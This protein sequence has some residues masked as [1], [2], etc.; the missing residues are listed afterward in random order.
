M[1]GTNEPRKIVC[2]TVNVNEPGQP[3]LISRRIKK[4]L[5]KVCSHCGNEYDFC[6]DMI[7]N[8]DTKTWICKVC[9]N[10]KK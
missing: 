1:E 9:A 7:Y 2:N 8:I 3:S 4:L 10:N 6:L 5:T